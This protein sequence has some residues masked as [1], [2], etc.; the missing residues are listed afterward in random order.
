MT[1]RQQVPR[2]LLAGGLAAAANFG[3]RFVFNLWVGYE[4]AVVLAFLVGLT[5][6]FLLMRAYV[7]GA[8]DKPLGPQ[9]VKYVA[10]NL[11]ALLQTLL[12]SVA[13]ARWAL[14]A[15]GFSASYAQSGGHLAGVLAP[16][17]T[18]YVLHR[19]VTFK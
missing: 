4:W 16:I 6:G 1:W 17:A 10:V 8:H 7:F 15:L 14:P 9:V 11:F 2:F 5:V 3:S 19:R 13:L 18:S 12:I